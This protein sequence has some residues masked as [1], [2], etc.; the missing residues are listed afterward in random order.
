MGAHEEKVYG[1]LLLLF[2]ACKRTHVEPFPLDADIVTLPS[3]YTACKHD[4]DCM[5]IS[6]GCCHPTAINRKY[7]DKGRDGLPANELCPPKG[8]CGPSAHGTWDGEPG[9]CVSGVCQMFR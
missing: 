5:V 9:V 1:V 4:A 6:N 7:E 3:A 2:C 8:A